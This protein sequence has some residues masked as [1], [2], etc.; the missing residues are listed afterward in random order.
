MG[1]LETVAKYIDEYLKGRTPEMAE[2]FRNKDVDKQYFSI[3]QWKRKQRIESLTPKNAD[4]IV[5]NLKNVKDLINNLAE[6]T[7][8]DMKKINLTLDEIQ[9]CL[10]DYMTKQRVRKIQELEQKQ[11]EIARQLQE[12]R[13]EEPNL[14]SSVL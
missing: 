13:G 8:E 4:E 3:M 9:V 7:P 14:F 10:N 1:K 2:K 12:L 6:L 11:S 5:A